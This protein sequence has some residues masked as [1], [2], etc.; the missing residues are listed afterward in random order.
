MAMSNIKYLAGYSFKGTVI[1][2]KLIDVPTSHMAGEKVS[3][4][5]LYELGYKPQVLL[6]GKDLEYT[7]I[8][9]KS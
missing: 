5:I 8:I 7:W 4:E 6:E 1:V 2:V 9:D 3:K